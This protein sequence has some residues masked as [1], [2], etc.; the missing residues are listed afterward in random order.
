[1]LHHHVYITCNTQPMNG[2]R[3]VRFWIC[4]DMFSS[5]GCQCNTAYILYTF[6]P[7]VFHFRLNWKTMFLWRRSWFSL[8]LSQ[9]SNNTIQ[10]TNILRTH[11]H[12][13]TGQHVCF[14]S[15]VLL[16]FQMTSNGLLYGEVVLNGHVNYNPVTVCNYMH[17]PIN[18]AYYG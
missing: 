2:T 4:S 12:T 18:Q 7:V 11:K 16:L 9:V 6:L 5:G 10:Y 8:Y 1:M 3:F 15:N 13:S 14:T 17:L